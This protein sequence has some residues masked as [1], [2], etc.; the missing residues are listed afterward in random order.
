MIAIYEPLYLPGQPLTEPAFRPL[1]LQTNDY[2]SWR[3]FRILTDMY[4]RGLHRQ[5]RFTGLL[6]PKFELKTGLSGREFITFVEANADADVCFAN[7]F[8]HYAYLAYNIWMQGEPAHPGLADRSQA[9]LNAC[10]IDLK[11]DE[12]PRHGPALLCFCN[13]WV[14]SERFWDEYVGRLLLPIAQFIEA[15]PDH[16]ACRAILGPTVHYIEST[17][18]LPFMIE[19]LFSSYLSLHAERLSIR[20]FARDPLQACFDDFERKLVSRIRSRIDDADRTGVFLHALRLE[21]AEQCENWMAH[22]LARYDGEHNP[23]ALGP[24]EKFKSRAG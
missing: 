22:F 2:A 20:A 21:I 18:F 3:E 23:H 4:R 16:P 6:S 19:R 1:R 11:I 12:M 7:P 17:P 8:P 24:V 10:G 13:Y 9:L 14:G 15:N 5:Q